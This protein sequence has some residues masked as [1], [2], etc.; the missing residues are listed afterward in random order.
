M[1]ALRASIAWNGEAR[2]TAETGSGHRVVI[3]GP[4]EFGGAN[5]GARPLELLLL[6][7]GGCAA[8]EVVRILRKSRQAVADCVADVEAE[9]AETHPGVFT[10]VHLRFRI[11]GRGLNARQVAR[12]IRLTAEQYCPAAVM[13]ARGGVA[14]THDFELVET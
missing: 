1:S 4:A 13:L 9:Q 5:A 2:F 10:R 14:V 11:A 12:A 3:D 6:G 8:F 7:V